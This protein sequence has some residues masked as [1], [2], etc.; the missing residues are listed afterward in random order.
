MFEVMAPFMPS[1][2]PGVGN[3]FDW[4]HPDYVQELLGGDFEVGIEERDTVLDAESGEQVWP[5][6]ST[7]YGPTKTLVG[8]LDEERREQLHR[9]W[10]K[11]FES[12]RVGDRIQQSRTYLLIT[13]HRR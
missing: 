6:F 1:P 2:I 5:T 11:L 4:G 8:S 10:V 12:S 3:V 13:G 7:A 9:D